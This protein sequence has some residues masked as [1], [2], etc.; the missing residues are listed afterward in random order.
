M[1]QKLDNNEERFQICRFNGTSDDGR[2]AVKFLSDSEIGPVF[3]SIE[4]ATKSRSKLLLI[5]CNLSLI[6]ASVPSLRADS[7]GRT[8]NPV[9]TRTP[10]LQTICLIPLH[11][12]L[13]LF[14]KYIISFHLKYASSIA[15]GCYDLISMLIGS[16]SFILIIANISVFWMSSTM[17]VC[18]GCV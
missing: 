17:C 9:L 14:P 8:L 18:D 6:H 5:K 2:A 4:N 12:S 13:F 1:Q 11:H 15:T 3:S 10:S 16:C 7:T